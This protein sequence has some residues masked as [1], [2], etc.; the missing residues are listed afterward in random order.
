MVTLQ[1][2]PVVT[3]TKFQLVTVSNRKL[4]PRLIATVSIKKTDFKQSSFKTFEGTKNPTQTELEKVNQ[5]I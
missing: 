2:V 4:H 1:R 5:F 3:I